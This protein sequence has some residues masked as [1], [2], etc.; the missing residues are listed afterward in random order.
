[1]VP[2]PARPA[3]LKKALQR[4]SAE[5]STYR[6]TYQAAIANLGNFHVPVA[7]AARRKAVATSN[8]IANNSLH[9]KRPAS[10]MLGGLFYFPGVA[11]KV[12]SNCCWRRNPPG[13]ARAQSAS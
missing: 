5:L 9:E 12:S 4:A 1:M 2:R 7:T 6:V 13:T 11:A 10:D 3:I 8:G